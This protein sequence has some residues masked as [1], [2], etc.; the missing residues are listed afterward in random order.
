MA[1]P[2]GSTARRICSVLKVLAQNPEGLGVRELARC[3]GFS[4][5]TLHHLVT[6]MMEEG[7]LRKTDSEL[8]QLGTEIL[9]IGVVALAEWDLRSVALPHLTRLAE[10]SGAAATINVWNGKDVIC[11]EVVE[12]PRGVLWTA[13]IGKAY[14]LTSGAVG[15]SIL[16][17]LGEHEHEG[18]VSSVLANGAARAPKSLEVIRETGVALSIGEK[19]P[20]GLAVAAPVWNRIG[21]VDANLA[22]V[23]PAEHFSAGQILEIAL[24]LREAANQ[25]SLSLGAP[26]A[27]LARYAMEL[28]RPGS[29]LDE[30]LRDYLA[31][32]LRSSHQRLATVSAAVGY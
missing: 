23:G 4:V 17:F 28:Y 12:A 32:C 9:R 7:L 25:V 31:D 15:K 21:Q 18:V 5:G 22:V 29:H 8:Y 6:T 1:R 2:S 16:A 27:L 24:A 20:G 26:A 3:T 10:L 11:I 13:K 19:C 30:L 14:P